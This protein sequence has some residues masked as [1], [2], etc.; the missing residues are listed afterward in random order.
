M[1]YG[2]L[3]KIWFHVFLYVLLV[4]FDVNGVLELS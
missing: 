4:N 1:G 3:L 2:Q